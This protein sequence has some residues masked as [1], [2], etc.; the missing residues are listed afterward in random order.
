[1]AVLPC[2]DVANEQ[3]GEVEATW[4][5]EAPECCARCCLH[6]VAMGHHGAAQVAPQGTNGACLS[7]IGVAQV[8][9]SRT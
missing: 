9:D 3:A 4:A 2:G 6:R 5:C 8:R 1:M 7:K